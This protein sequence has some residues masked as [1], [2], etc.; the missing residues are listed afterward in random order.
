MKIY[1]IKSSHQHYSTEILISEGGFMS[2]ILEVTIGVIQVG[3]TQQQCP[4]L[5]KEGADLF[6]HFYGL[7]R[8]QVFDHLEHQDEIEGFFN[9]P[10]AVVILMSLSV[11]VQTLVHDHRGYLFDFCFVTTVSCPNLQDPDSF[12]QVRHNPVHLFFYQ[13]DVPYL[14]IEVLYLLSVPG[15]STPTLNVCHLFP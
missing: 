11:Y 3:G 7:P 10:D 14:R 8:S 1:S 13:G 4:T 9:I 5:S 15:N 2:N 6:K 12:P